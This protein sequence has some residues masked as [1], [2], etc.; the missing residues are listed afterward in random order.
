[1]GV[2][3]WEPPSPVLILILLLM[4]GRQE[5]VNACGAKKWPLDF[6]ICGSATG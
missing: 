4:G 1:M 3:P 6:M 2:H 5:M